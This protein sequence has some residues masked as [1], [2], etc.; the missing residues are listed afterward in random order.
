VNLSVQTAPY[1]PVYGLGTSSVPPYGF[2][3]PVVQTGLDAKN[4]PTFTKAGLSVMDPNMKTEYTN[5]YSLGLQSNLGRGWVGEADYIGS[6][7]RHEYSDTEVNR[8]NGDLIQNKGQLTRLN[9]SFGGIAYAQANLNSNYSGVTAALRNLGW[10]GLTT[11]LAYTFGKALDQASNA[12]AT[13]TATQGGDLNIVDP[14][15]TRAEYGRADFD[16]RHRVSLSLL[17]ELPSPGSQ[18]RFVHTLLAGWEIGDITILQSGLPLSVFC[19]AAFSPVITGTTVTGNTGCDYNADGFNY[20]RPNVAADANAAR[21]ISRK[22]YLSG[23]F[24]CATQLCG[25]IFSAPALGQEGTLGRNT[26]QNPGYADSDF[27]LIKNTHA[28]LFKRDINVQLRAEGLNIF[29]RDN[30]N[31]VSGDIANATTF[32]KATSSVSP[33][34]FQ[35]GARVIF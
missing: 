35:F 27:S 22:Q 16:V 13:G 11:Q 33:R 18:E 25:N 10:H 3:T 32:G 2:P 9:T 21:G 30:L 19:S 8:F 20:D 17:Y 24:N 29:N 1:V 5:N 7:G 4:G 28:E 15:N 6:I 23:M 26:F 12:G 34:E 31:F 14:N